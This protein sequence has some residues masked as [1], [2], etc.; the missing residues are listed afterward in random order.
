MFNSS[1]LRGVSLLALTIAI[2]PVSPQANAQVVID[3]GN[4]S[5]QGADANTNNPG[6]TN[7]GTPYTPT[8]GLEIGVSGT[9]TLIS[10]DGIISSSTT[11]VGKT[12]TGTLTLQNEASG[13]VV[14]NASGSILLGEN[15]GAIGTLTVS[16]AN[17]SIAGSGQDLFIGFNGEGVAQ[18]DAG[19]SVVMGGLNVGANSA[20]SKGTLVVDGLGTSLILDDNSS[21]MFTIAGSSSNQAQMTISNGALVDS[22]GNGASTPR[23]FVGRQAGSNALMTITG[24]S[25]AT[26]ST[27]DHNG[28]LTIGEFGVG[29]IELKNSG[30]LLVSNNFEVGGNSAGDGT[31]NISTGGKATLGSTVYVGNA[32]GSTGLI[33]VD[34]AG[35]E[36][37]STDAIYVG[38]SGTGTI[39]VKNGA[40][41]SSNGGIVVGLSSGSNG[42]VVV[43]GAGSQFN[44][45][46]SSASILVGD[47]GTGSLTVSNGAVVTSDGGLD[48][49]RFSTSSQGTVTLTG[50]G[51]TLTTKLSTSTVGSPG[52]DPVSIGRR[53]TGILN[54]LDGA[55]FTSGD[56]VTT[57]FAKVGVE[58]NASGTVT[59]SGTNSAWNHSGILGIARSGT[60]VVS[61]SDSG[62][63]VADDINIAFAAGSI[64]TLNIGGADGS[65]ATSAGT[66]TAT[67]IAAGAGTA[68]LNFNHTDT[69]YSFATKLDG[70][71]TVNNTAGTTN[72]TGDLSSFTGTIN[73]NG[74]SLYINTTVANA[75]AI[76]VNGGT[77]G[78]A[79]T[80]NAI[81]IGNGGTLA[82]GNSIGTINISGNASLGAGSTYA[83]EID[84][85]GNT[86]LLNVGGTLSIDPTAVV[87]LAPENG[88]DDGSTYTI[89]QTYT[90][91]TA[92]GG[93]T[94]TFAS[95]T[96]SFAFI[97]GELS[98][99]ANNVILTLVQA[100]NFN[101]V[102][103]TG[104]QTNVANAV[105]AL[106]S[107]NSVFT[108]LATLT[109]AQ[110]QA[111]FN[112]LSGEI[113]ASA[114]SAFVND[115]RY[116]RDAS[117]SRLDDKQFDGNQA[118]I[119]VYGGLS[120]LGSNSNAADADV[121]SGGIIA[122][123]ETSEDN[124]LG[125]IA[126][127]LGASEISIDS[128][129]D[130]VAKS[131]DYGIGGYG[132]FNVENMR[133]ALGASYT[134]HSIKTSRNI[135]F[136]SLTE[137]IAGDYDASTAQ[138]FAKLSTE[139]ETVY[140]NFTP[141][142]QIATIRHQTD[143]FTESGGSSALSNA[144]T[145]TSTTFTVLG[146]S[147]QRFTVLDNGKAAKFSGT[148]GWQHAFGDRSANSATNFSGGQQFNV[149]GASISQDALVLKFGS[150]VQMN[151]TTNFNFDYSGQI[152]SGGSHSHSGRAGLSVKF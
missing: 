58:T 95:I 138:L 128:S 69:N 57:A 136:G 120:T 55:V 134:S 26:N 53:G 97:D 52:F 148:I 49:A 54:I 135:A 116:L 14:F 101:S 16:G 100:A 82:P 80:L 63:L 85:A 21:T 117:L 47:V 81:S 71:L 4:V 109:T 144:A 39:N 119:D 146:V 9:G 13:T 8:G 132:A 28:S 19:A 145:D 123:L 147:A 40:V 131:S 61:V 3:G 38:G 60:G 67:Q 106:G 122:G 79:G 24:S 137:T 84:S 27:W 11:T 139:L 65:A 99:S 89:G 72:V 104:N 41:A 50:A 66:V 59:I 151:E 83:V 46:T 77:L 127:Q 129:R 98:Y 5:A 25:G 36:L 42:T 51:T 62:A 37:N 115:S 126:V 152:G 32:A 92:T 20:T 10:S 75:A 23:A 94:G 107:N 1:L 44:F 150:E 124:W 12:D 74:G 118:W 64:G 102:A 7:V 34:G 105:Q 142:A 91:A 78:G 141:F 45:V 125:G 29:A 6:A 35:S 73:A 108:S 113:H 31:L 143:G 33:E 86:D 15:A 68:T 93:V 88:T 103:T 149:E 90:I 133:L 96:D 114:K 76:N 56:G 130:S 140:G 17:T 22:G 2:L 121:S 112:A 48:V 18:I 111:A 110:A 43:D 87:N 30:E 70:D